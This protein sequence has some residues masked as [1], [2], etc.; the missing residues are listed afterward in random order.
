MCS[1][2]T[3]GFTDTPLSECTHLLQKIKAVSLC[4]LLSSVFSHLPSLFTVGLLLCFVPTA[5][6]T[7]ESKA[8]TLR[9]SP[10]K[11]ACAPSRKNAGQDSNL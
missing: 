10:L 11:G 2:I 1:N 4:S 3:A 9:Y 5:E 8:Q 6:T 7:S